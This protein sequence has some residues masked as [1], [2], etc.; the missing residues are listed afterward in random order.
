MQD[1]SASQHNKYVKVTCSYSGCGGRRVH[2][3]RP[4]ELRKPVE[5]EVPPLWAKGRCYCSME[6]YLY[7]QA[8]TTGTNKEV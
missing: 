3:E 6:C 8:K 5:F 7:D 1:M 2:H 4:Y